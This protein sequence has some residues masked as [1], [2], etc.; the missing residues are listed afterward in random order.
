MARDLPTV[1]SNS[2]IGIVIT[3]T[4]NSANNDAIPNNGRRTLHVKNGSGGSINV[5]IKAPAAATVGGIPL[6]DKVVAVANSAEAEFGP[7]GAEWNQ[8]DGSVYIDYS[9]TT[10]VTRQVR[11]RPVV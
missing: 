3:L 9:S 4:A 2:P 6:S 11:E 1:A 10:T 7:W 8:P 5:T